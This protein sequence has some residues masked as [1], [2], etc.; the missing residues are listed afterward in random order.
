MQRVASANGL[1][2]PLYAQVAD[3]MRQRL[4]DLEWAPGRAMPTEIV[5]AKEIGVSV[6]TMRKALE[7]LEAEKL[8]VRKQGRGT[9]VKEMTAES[10]ALQFW[11]INDDGGPLHIEMTV[12]SC[13]Y[14]VADASEARALELAP[15]H[16][17]ARIHRRHLSS[18]LRIDEHISLDRDRFGGIHEVADMT[19]PVLFATYRHDYHV[20]ISATEERVWAQVCDPATA[21]ALEIEPGTPLIACDRVARERS[22]RPAEWSRQRVFMT[23]PFIVGRSG[24]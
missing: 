7:A 21:A 17:V 14:S 20:V 23:G 5:L 16:Q 1:T 6:G 4:N 10:E 18:A 12:V 2:G 3:I 11:R 15:G 9:F 24:N 22:G 13:T 19:A 8:I